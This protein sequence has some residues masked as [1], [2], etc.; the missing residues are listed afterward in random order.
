MS[1]APKPTDVELTAAYQKLTPAQANV[2]RSKCGIC[3][4]TLGHL[5][6]QPD[7]VKSKYLALANTPALKES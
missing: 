6:R 7:A 4:N 1:D 5:L 2:I 3:D